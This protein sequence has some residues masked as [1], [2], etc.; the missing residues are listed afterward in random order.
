M[1]ELQDLKTRVNEGD[2]IG[3]H[4]SEHFTD[5]IDALQDK[6]KNLERIKAL[7]TEDS[8]PTGLIGD[9]ESRMDKMQKELNDLKVITVARGVDKFFYLRVLCGWV[10]LNAMSSVTLR[11][12]FW[13]A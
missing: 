3:R 8:T 6:L 11:L 7:A 12:K 2:E 1:A 5:E 13:G 9:M 4:A 10:I